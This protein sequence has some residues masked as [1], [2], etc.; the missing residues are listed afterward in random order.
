MSIYDF[1]FKDMGAPIG[2]EGVV[3]L[4]LGITGG[5]EYL[6]SLF[7]SIDFNIHEDFISK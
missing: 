5:A 7:W 6:Q 2:R 1:I 4:E 3:S